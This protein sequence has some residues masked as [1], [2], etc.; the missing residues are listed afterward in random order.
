MEVSKD[1]INLLYN[2]FNWDKEDSRKIWCFGPLETGPNCMVEKT[3]GVQYMN[4]I[5]EHVTAGF[6][7]ATNE[8]ALCQENMRGVKFS[9]IDVKLIADAIHRGG[10][11]I[12]PAAR[13]VCY[14]A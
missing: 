13:R 3:V 7:W 6:Q 10:G 11:Q 9:L 4:E 14:A 1:F 2:D 5:R 8:G 12:T